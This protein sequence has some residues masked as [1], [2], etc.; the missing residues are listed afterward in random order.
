MNLF[1]LAAIVLVGLAALGGYRSGFLARA[2]SWAGL[3]LGAIVA[4][5]FIPTLVELIPRPNPAERLVVAVAVLLL[6]AAF[7]QGLGLLVGVRARLSLPRAGVPVDQ[8]VGALAGGLS[9]LVGLWLLLPAMAE[10]P[11]TLSRQARASAIGQAIDEVAPA[12]PDALR[13]LRQLVRET[14]FPQ[15]FA[16]LRPSPDLVPPPAGAGPSPAVVAA[17]TGSTVRVEGQACGRI[18]EGSGFVAQPG[19]VVTNAH[20]VAGEHEI[21]LVSPGGAQVAARVVVFDPNRDLALLAAPRLGASPL[22]L[23]DAGVGDVGAVFGYPG[24]GAL[25]VAPYAVRDE[26]EALGRDLYDR[27]PTRRQVLILASGLAPGD[28]GGALVDGDGSV[29]GVAFAIAPDRAATA[30]ALATEEVEAVLAAPRG[31]ADTGPCL[32]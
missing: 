2:L 20:V 16:D 4:V 28:S 21:E 29:V 32:R 3:V 12:P 6:G 26:V 13:T 11:G 25:R 23:G 27:R 19:V 8:V 14:P 30:Y 15:V 18:Q 10:V 7:G 17:V 5:V 22:P 31:E 1:D 9:V 24:G